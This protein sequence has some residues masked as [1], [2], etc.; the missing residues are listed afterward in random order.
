MQSTQPSIEE[1]TKSDTD[2]D[3]NGWPIGFFEET[4]GSIPDFPEREHQGE[5]E[6]RLELDDLLN[7]ITGENQH[8]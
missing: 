2:V 4:A 1:Q 5:Y 3:A 8:T 6:E 7:D